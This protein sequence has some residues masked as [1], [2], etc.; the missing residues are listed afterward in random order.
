MA[1]EAFRHG[2]A[3]L[4]TVT[5]LH[6]LALAEAR[7]KTA[8]QGT[9]W[10]LVKNRVAYSEAGVR[11]VVEF[12]T[13]PIEDEAIAGVPVAEVLLRSLL[14]ELAPSPV[15]PVMGAVC[16]FYVN[17]QL[18]GVR[19]PDSTVVNV[20]VATAQNFVRGMEV[21]LKPLGEGRYELA[22]KLPRTPGKW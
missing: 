8:R 1:E 11:L 9:H 7:K 10:A 13:G 2:E 22:R 14:E 4:A 3:A 16:A 15:P 21:P 12:L 6:P 19:L 18:I 17:R 5:G 20:R